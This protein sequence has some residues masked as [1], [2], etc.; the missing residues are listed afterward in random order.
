MLT[1]AVV[2]T[3]PGWKNFTADDGKTLKAFLEYAA[4]KGQSDVPA[5]SFPLPS[6]LD[7][8]TKTVAAKIP[9]SETSPQSSGGHHGQGGTPGG[10]GSGSPTGGSGSGAFTGGSG[11]G[12]STGTGGTGGTGGTAPGSTTHLKKLK[13]VHKKPLAYSLTAKQLSTPSSSAIVPALAALA[14]FGLVFGPTVLLF[15]RGRSALSGRSLR[16]I[17][18]GGSGSG[19]AS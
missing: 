14:L 12:A 5:G 4:A 13:P 15:S 9:T 17:L 2:P 18:P 10:S 3:N 19:A 16:N 11:G 7:A 1:Y 8:D 6:A